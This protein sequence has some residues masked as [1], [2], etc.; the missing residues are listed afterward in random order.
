[1]A[2]QYKK[3]KID[4]D[5]KMYVYLMKRLFDDI[6]ES[7]ACNMDIIDAM[8]N[9][10]GTPDKSD[11]WAFTMLDKFILLI[12]KQVGHDNLKS[13]IS[14]FE[15][16]K[17]IDPLFIMNMKA[18]TNLHTV[19][20]TF[21]KIVTAVNDKEYLPESLYHD[22]SYV[23]MKEE[24]LNYCD[25]VSKALTIA[26]FLVYTIRHDRV[27]T[28]IEFDGSIINSVEATFNV[29]AIGSYDEIK[30]FCE[31]NNLIDHNNITKEGIKLL[32]RLSKII[33]SGNILSTNRDRIENQAHNWKRLSG[34]EG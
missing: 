30:K 17:N 12:K 33:V 23:E 26:T 27:P 1:M 24:V 34:V 20:D 2:E 21:D 14:N 11:K 16:I 15:Y 22:D 29:R 7:D 3:T 6:Q 19:K 4:F 31:D 18:G 25:Y 8:G 28:T 5:N 13:L 32:V 9:I 10:I